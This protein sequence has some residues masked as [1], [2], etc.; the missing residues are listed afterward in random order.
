MI[1]PLIGLGQCVSGDCENGYGTYTWLSG[2]IYKGEWKAGFK[3][4]QGTFTW[5]NPWEKYVGELKDNLYDGI[6]KL[7]Y[8]DGRVEEG[9]F[10]IGV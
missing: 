7:T 10:M 1:V 9:R 2:D 3:E 8:S 5:Q 4:G 6:G